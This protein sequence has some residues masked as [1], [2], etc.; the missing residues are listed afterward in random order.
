MLKNR[1]LT[2]RTPEFLVNVDSILHF[3]EDWKWKYIRFYMEIENT[4]QK[5]I[6]KCK[7]FENITSSTVIFNSYTFIVGSTV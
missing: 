6:K 5:I 7:T 1:N 4:I 2:A 3:L